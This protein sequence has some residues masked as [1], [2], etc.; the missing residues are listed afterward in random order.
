MA[1]CVER[2]QLSAYRDEGWGVE[3]AQ[4]LNAFTYAEWLCRI[5]NVLATRYADNALDYVPVDETDRNMRE[6]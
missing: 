6:I 1:H 5:P 3:T 2:V 4:A